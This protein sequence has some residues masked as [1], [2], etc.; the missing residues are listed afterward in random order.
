MEKHQTKKI[1]VLPPGHATGLTWYVTHPLRKNNI[2]ISTVYGAQ[3]VNPGSA[4][5]SIYNILFTD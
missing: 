5:R 4:S 3:L 1:E 2:M